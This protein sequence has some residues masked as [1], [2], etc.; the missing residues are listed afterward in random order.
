MMRAKGLLCPLAVCVAASVCACGP[1]SNRNGGGD[2]DPGVDANGGGSGGGGGGGGGT[3]DAPGCSAMD[4]LFVIDNSGSMGQEQANLIANFPMFIQVLDASGL[5]Y[6]VAVT[7]TARDYTYSMF[8][9]FNQSTS[10]ESGE[11]IQPGSCNMTKRWIDKTDPN[12]AQTFSC[13]ANVGTG[14]SSDEMPLGAIRDAFEDRMTD[15]TN[16]GFRRPDAL[17]GVVVLTDE[18]DCSYEQSVS[19]G[20]GESLCDSQME[21]TINYKTFLDTYTGGPS[22]WAT[23]IIAGPGPGTCSSTFGNADEATRLINFKNQVGANAMMSSICDGDLSPALMQA[24]ALFE[25]ACGAIIL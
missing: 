5:D 18:N 25:S 8:G 17:L 1:T 12:P 21:P 4:L 13:A 10:G 15:G 23:A 6:R 16:M 22:R 7:T 19:L 20:F 3:V 14:G 24:L 11:M 2:D 9:T